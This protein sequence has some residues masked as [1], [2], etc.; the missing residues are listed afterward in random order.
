MTEPKQTPLASELARTRLRI[1][2]GEVRHSQKDEEEATDALWMGLYYALSH[3]NFV[4]TDARNEFV[5]RLAGEENGVA[6]KVG[7]WEG[8]WIRPIHPKAEEPRKLPLAYDPREREW[9]GSEVDPYR[10]RYED[11]SPRLRYAMDVLIDEVLRLFGQSPI[12]A[13]PSGNG[14][15][16]N[17]QS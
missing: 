9:V 10:P 7:K 15:G 4:I 17:F 14:S 1:L 5:V 13:V 12:L 2:G 6:L 11:G 3:A 16:M 8:V